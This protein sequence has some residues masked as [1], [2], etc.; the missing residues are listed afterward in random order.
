MRRY[1]YRVD[2]RK[3]IIIVIRLQVHHSVS[4]GPRTG[5]VS[6]SVSRHRVAR[7]VLCLTYDRLSRERAIL[8]LA[9]HKDK[10]RNTSPLRC[11]NNI[12]IRCGGIALCFCVFRNGSGENIRVVHNA[13]EQNIIMIIVADR[14]VIS[15]KRV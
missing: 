4:S 1:T 8:F 14:S 9:E 12:I 10:Q 11:Y 15:P 6:D 3:N 13:R 2:P 5:M 7:A